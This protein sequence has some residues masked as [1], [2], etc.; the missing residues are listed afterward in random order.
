MDRVI[1]VGDLARAMAG[2]GASPVRDGATVT[3]VDLEIAALSGGVP[4]G[5]AIWA[6]RL[7]YPDAPRIGW[8]AGW[9]RAQRR[10]IGVDV[11][12]LSLHWVPSHLDALVDGRFVAR[13][14]LTA[15]GAIVDE[16]APQDAA[17]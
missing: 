12:R 14:T 5:A 8:L 17:A 15:S 11:A 3:A 6:M 7:R 4:A 1:S 13:L 9:R 16:P 2:A 10:R